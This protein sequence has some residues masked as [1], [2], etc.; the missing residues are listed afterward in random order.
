MKTLIKPLVT[1]KL[2]SLGEKFNRV[3]FIVDKM[4]RRRRRNVFAL[5]FFLPANTM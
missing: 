1:E 5:L 2:T 4:A 3:G